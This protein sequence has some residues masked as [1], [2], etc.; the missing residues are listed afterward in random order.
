MGLQSQQIAIYWY[1]AP[2]QYCLGSITLPRDSYQ[3]ILMWF[4]YST[5]RKTQVDLAKWVSNRVSNPGQWW[6]MPKRCCHHYTQF[7]QYFHTN[8]HHYYRNQTV[9]V[10]DSVRNYCLAFFGYHGSKCT[11][12]TDAIQKYLSTG[13]KWEITSVSAITFLCKTVPIAKDTHKLGTL[14]NTHYQKQRKISAPSFQ[15]KFDVGREKIFSQWYSSCCCLS[16]K[17]SQVFQYFSFPQAHVHAARAHTHK[18]MQK[19]LSV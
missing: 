4:D 9:D 6:N 7:V 13:R 15:T 12:D 19:L 5:Q 18:A 1:T 8:N 11:E 10:G 14:V 3:L 2:S 17:I 16:L